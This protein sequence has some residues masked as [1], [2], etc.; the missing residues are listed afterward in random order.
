MW[1]LLGR[2]LRKAVGLAAQE[3]GTSTEVL[4]ER[5]RLVLVGHSRLK[6]A[7]DLDCKSPP[8]PQDALFDTSWRP[9]MSV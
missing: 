1:N 8:L 3:V 6:A 4:V 7:L 9:S 2:A 5:A